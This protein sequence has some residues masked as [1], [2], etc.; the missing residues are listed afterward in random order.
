MKTLRIGS[1]A[2]LLFL[3]P[4]VL[5]VAQTP[6]GP[7]AGTWKANLSKCIFP[8]TPPA[9]DMVTVGEDGR[10]TVNETNAQGKSNTWTYM[11]V[12]GQPVAVEGRDHVTVTNHRVNLR[13]TEQTWDFNGRAA[14]SK[15]SVSRDGKTQTFEMDSVDKDGKPTHEKVVYEKQ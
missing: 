10:I 4:S 6:A 15:A 14:K 7:F 11:P 8:G 3:V 12:E 5:S 9:V 13:H 1:L 2:V